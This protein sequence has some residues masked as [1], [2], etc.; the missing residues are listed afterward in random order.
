MLND[1]FNQV[2]IRYPS[3]RK[4]E[5]FAGHSLGEIV[6]K[7][8]PEQIKNAGIL[9]KEYIIKGSVGQGAWATV[10]WIAI[11]DSRITTTTQNGVYIVYLFTENGSAVYLTFNQGCT[12]LIKSNGRSEA[13]RFLLSMAEGIRKNISVPEGFLTDNDMVIGNRFYE[14]GCIAYKC[15]KRNAI[16]ADDILMTD[17]A[18]LCMVYEKYY[19]HNSNNEGLSPAPEKGNVMVNRQPAWTLHE[20]VI[21]LDG[22][23]E[24][25]KGEQPRLRIIKRISE[26]LRTMTTNNDVNIDAVYRNEN[27]ISFQMQ[28]M[29]SAYLGYTV[30]GKPAT[31]LFADTVELYKSDLQQYEKILKE[32]KAMIEGEKTIKER[33]TEWLENHGSNTPVSFIN[34]YTKSVEDFARKKKIFRTPLLEMTDLACLKKLRFFIGADKSYRFQHKRDIK[35]IMQYVAAYVDYIAALP[36]KEEIV[37]VPVELEPVIETKPEEVPVEIVEEIPTEGQQIA[38]LSRNHDY[39]FTKPL[40]LTYKGQTASYNKWG[41]LYIGILGK[42]YA[43]YP[44]AFEAIRDSLAVRSGALL[45]ASSDKKDSFR[46]PAEF[47]EDFFVEANHSATGIVNKTVKFLD[48]CKVSYSDVVIE[49]TKRGAQSSD[50]ENDISPVKPRHEETPLDPVLLDAVKTILQQC[51]ALGYR[52]GDSIAMDIFKFY[53]EDSHHAQP[54]YDDAMLERYIKA[55]GAEYNGFIYC[56]ETIMDDAMEQ[57]VIASIERNFAQGVSVVFFESLFNEYADD[58]LDY[59]VY[60][61]DMLKSYLTY[62]NNGRYHI[63]DNCLKQDKDA[64]LDTVAEV[65][66]LLLHTGRPMDNQEIIDTLSYIPEG[67]IRS[68]FYTDDKIKS[69]GRGIVFHVDT[70]S[71][72]DDDLADIAKII[73]NLIMDKE[74]ATSTEV[75]SALRQNYPYILENNTYFRDTGIRNA[76]E[77]HLNNMFTFNNNIITAIGTVLSMKD[78][79]IHYAKQRKYFSKG[80]LHEFA[81]SLGTQVYFDAVSTVSMRISDSNYVPNEDARFDIAA[82]DDAISMYCTGDYMPI[83]DVDSFILFPSAGHP[84][85]SYLLENYIAKFSEQFKLIHVNFTEDS[86]VGV[87][88]RKASKYK[89]MT[90]IVTDEL[91]HSNC[92]LK[93]VPALEY[94]VER[95]FITSRRW[96]HM[97]TLIGEAQVLRNRRC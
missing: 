2:L 58:F 61:A 23:F 77:Y 87:I 57:K 75:L 11:M 42:L 49:Y 39:S 74:F 12:D 59:K 56:P 62:K 64:T 6:R 17:L 38:D 71:A 95:G 92:V 72:T 69:G 19:S 22:Y 48:I 18:A 14:K 5:Q 81:K 70:F 40:A 15:Y 66:G 44:E 43:D 55:C 13:I 88:V 90:S 26:D 82:T 86:T 1:S 52:C 53:F 80:E 89:D 30:K 21:L 97:E 31:K 60:D 33:F 16:P 84:W 54:V 24:T 41:T 96:D 7:K 91:A 65:E 93:K 37:S 25:V 3:A 50:E 32:S 79:F 34:F 45:L 78:L 20:A 9:P 85:N 73:R 76:I 47:A 51:F 67:K 94:L 8:I 83:G 27:G 29:E 63:E 46:M 10:P 28:S 35:Q 68:V 4:L 36:K